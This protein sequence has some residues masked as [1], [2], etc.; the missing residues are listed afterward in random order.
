[1]KI[2]VVDEFREIVNGITAVFIDSREGFELLQKKLGVEADAHGLDQKMYYGNGRK[3]DAGIVAVSTTI[4]ERIDRN[5]CDA[6]NCT[7][8]GNMALV[9]IY[10]F[11]E[12]HY[13]EAI[14]K[15]FKKYNNKNELSSDIMGDIRHLRTSIVHNRS[16]AK[17]D[18]TKCKV[19]CWFEPG[20]KMSI[21]ESSYLEMVGLIH[22]YLDELKND[23]L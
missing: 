23:A 9:S 5:I 1:M 11:W 20:D 8:V 4:G 12:D 17:S 14:A 21:S 10:S 18:V 6:E 13:R 3:D 15:D 7:F 2:T 19:L 22:E 16:V